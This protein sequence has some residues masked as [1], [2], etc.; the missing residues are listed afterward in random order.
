MPDQG[1]FE[2]P[3]LLHQWLDRCLVSAQASEDFVADL[4]QSDQMCLRN[5]NCLFA[6]T[7]RTYCAIFRKHLVGGGSLLIHMRP[8]V[9]VRGCKNDV[10]P[11]ESRYLDFTRG[12]VFGSPAK[13]IHDL[14]PPLGHWQQ[15]HPW[16]FVETGPVASSCPAPLCPHRV[17]PHP[18][19]HA[20]PFG[21]ILQD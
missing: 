17:H 5:R 12:V 13:Y 6:P 1:S 10:F 20:Y 19:E 15:P 9:L 18:V 2:G 21:D 14:V 11:A 3:K 4:S 8:P 16:A 7:E